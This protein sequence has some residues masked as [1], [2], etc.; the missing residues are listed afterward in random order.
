MF[1]HVQIETTDK[2]K[3][4]NYLTVFDLDNSNL[5]DLKKY[6]FSP[7]LKRTEI[8]ID[9]RQLEY[10]RIR[11]IKIF[12]S[13]KTSNELRDIAQSKLSANI[14]MSYRKE[15]MVNDK[16]M[17]DITKSVLFDLAAEIKKDER[18]KID[19]VLEN[20]DK[21]T[22]SNKIFIVHGRENEVKIEIARFIELL[23]LEAIILHEQSNNGKTIIEKIEQ[24]SDVGYGIVLYT[25]CDVGSLNNP[26]EKLT[27]RA[28][29]NVIFEHGYLIGK[30]GRSKV[31]ALVKDGVEIPNDISGLVY[32]NFENNNGWKLDLGKELIGAGYDIDFNKLIK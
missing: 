28:R 30:L 16:Y 7:Y 26:D 15:H 6:I 25:P 24:Y 8:F 5:S 14:I 2:D 21:N 23:G 3:K 4:G 18:S 9:G 27:P 17:N 13:E 11:Q 31:S 22:I 1:Y 20:N 32:I 19:D 29:Q 10:S 12:E